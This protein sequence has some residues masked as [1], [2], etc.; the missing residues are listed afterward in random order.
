M[1]LR[2]T[3]QSTAYGWLMLAG[4]VVS[5]CL[6]A[7]LARRD[8]RLLMVYVAALI[9]AFAGAKV[10]YLL[11][12]GWR[13]I[14]QRDMWMQL[15]TGKTVLGALLGG[16][17][18]VEIAKKCVGYHGITGDWFALIAPIGIILG[19]IGCLLH[20]CCQ[21]KVC[22]PAWFTVTDSAGA[23]RWPSV[24]MEILFNLIALA[25]VCF[26]RQRRLLSGQHFHLYL[27]AYGAFRFFHEFLRNES[28]LL[29][30][31]TGY[32]LLAAG[33]VVFGWVAFILRRNQSTSAGEIKVA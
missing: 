8:D 13:V 9:G 17:L 24:P 1:M 25:V 6:W 32:Q 18:G 21:G 16:Y 28:R 20:G 27:I 22:E 29:G 33:V 12:D 2:A 14:G 26:L 4:I 19:R 15:A 31:F 11:V 23:A 7:R 3:P 10:F 5:I 30:P